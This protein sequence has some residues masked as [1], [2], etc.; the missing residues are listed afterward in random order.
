MYVFSQSFPQPF[1]FF[2]IVPKGFNGFAFIYQW[3]TNKAWGLKE[4]NKD[5]KAPLII[6]KLLY[7][8]MY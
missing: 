6:I 3:F 5:F 1:P 2:A 7:L 4:K 8:Q